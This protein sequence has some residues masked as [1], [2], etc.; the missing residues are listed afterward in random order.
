M[1]TYNDVYIEARKL[2]KQHD[3]P[4]SSL[5]A[6][7][8]VGGAAGKKKEELVRDLNLYVSDE[9]AERV[10]EM[11]LRRI[12]GEPA[13]YITGEWEFYGL[14][15]EITPDVLIPRNDTEVLAERAIELLRGRMSSTRV[16]DLC[17]GSGCVGLS[18]AANVSDC[19]VI[20]VD[21]SLKA[22]RVCRANVLKNNL[23]RNVTCIDADALETPPMLLGKFDMLV[24]NPPYIP[25]E[26]IIGLDPSVRDFEPMMALDGGTDGLDFYRQIISKWKVVLK[27]RGC[28]MF[29]CGIGQ[30]EAVSNIMAKNGFSGI[31]TFKD[32]LGIDRVVAGV[33]LHKDGGEF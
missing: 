33:L 21:K 23:G 30:A 9:F 27:D 24:C 11:C 15:L 6:R 10:H 31:Q 13:A 25:T 8:I 1:K 3:I 17:S 29:E 18:I 28:M 5:E 19:R 22:M 20:L 12:T 7:L 4:S 16:L 26:D 32:T 2:L 14:S